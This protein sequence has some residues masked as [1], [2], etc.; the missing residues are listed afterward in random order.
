M[1]V[2]RAAGHVPK[3]VDTTV[4]SAYA[5]NSARNLGRA[6]SAVIAVTGAVDYVIGADR[7]IALAGGSPMSQLVTG[8]GCAATACVGAFLGIER[9]ALLATVSALAVL[10]AAAAMAAPLA[11]GPGSFQTALLDALHHALAR[12]SGPTCG[13]RGGVTP[14]HAH[15][16][17]LSPCCRTWSRTRRRHEVGDLKMRDRER[18]PKCAENR[19]LLQFFGALQTRGSRLTPGAHP[20]F[21]VEINH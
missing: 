2:A 19:R 9:D 12:R 6:S 4:A 11:Q 16:R 18:A 1:A 3:G 8:T 13:D 10:K 15:R 7:G 14:Q 17:S 21:L 5:V 20:R